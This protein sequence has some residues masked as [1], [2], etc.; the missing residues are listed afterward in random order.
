MKAITK[1]FLEKHNACSS[2]MSWVTE[3]KLIGLAP[4][5]FIDTL[6]S[7]DKFDWANWLIVRLMNKKQKVQYAIFA[8]EQVLYIFE[9]KYPGDLRPRKA[10]EAA[11][12]YL[13]HP[14]IKTKRAAYATAAADAV[15]A[16]YAAADAAYAVTDAVDA[17][18][19]AAYAAY[20]AAAYAAA[21][22]AYAATDAA[23]AAADAAADAVDAAYAAAAYAAAD[24]AYARKQMQITIINYGL[25]LI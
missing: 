15:D 7:N 17:A 8:A 14:F 25:S 13:T 1:E 16:A 20:A 6:M 23:Y 5:E 24:A 21:D 22:A 9:K 18:Y 12:E 10:I 19:A 3:N 2:G 4:K 11:K